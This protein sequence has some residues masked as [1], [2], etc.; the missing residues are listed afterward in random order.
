MTDTTMERDEAGF[1]QEAEHCVE[2][3]SMWAKGHLRRCQ[4]LQALGR[5]KDAL[6][7]VMVAQDLSPYGQ[8]LEEAVREARFKLYRLTSLLTEEQ[9]VRCGPLLSERA[10]VVKHSRG[11]SAKQGDVQW[12]SQ[13]GNDITLILAARVDVDVQSMNQ[14]ERLHSFIYVG[15]PRDWMI[16]EDEDRMGP[17]QELGGN[18]GLGRSHHVLTLLSPLQDPL[19]CSHT[20]WSTGNTDP[21]YRTLFFVMINPDHP[22]F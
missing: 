16:L 13:L 8:G 15:D 10:H 1:L 14:E 11:L 9:L 22:G 19:S 6:A 7:A 21:D 3:D 18:M 4:A 2:A 17:K 12:V 5:D 20:S